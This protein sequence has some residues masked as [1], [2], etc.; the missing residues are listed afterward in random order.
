MMLRLFVRFMQMTMNISFTALTVLEKSG[1][2][3]R[4]VLLVSLHGVN[5]RL[6]ASTRQSQSVDALAANFLQATG[7]CF[8][9]FSISSQ[10]F[11]STCSYCALFDELSRNH[12][13]L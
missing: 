13:I 9:L 8:G 7:T 6:L 11:C 10:Y 2:S 4:L 12:I 3:I 1:E 5:Q